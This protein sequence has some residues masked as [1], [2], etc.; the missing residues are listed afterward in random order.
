MQVDFLHSHNRGSVLVNQRNQQETLSK[1]NDVRTRHHPALHPL[2]LI[3]RGPLSAIRIKPVLHSSRN[4]PS[5]RATLLET[6]PFS[7]V[8][9]INLERRMTKKNMNEKSPISMRCN[10][11]GGNLVEVA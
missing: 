9:Q 5:L 8:L 2:D 1:G 11:H 7:T 3:S 4:F 6:L 10:D